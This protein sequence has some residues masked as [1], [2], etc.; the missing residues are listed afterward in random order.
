[1]PFTFL[2]YK[3][4]FKNYDLVP[5]GLEKN[6]DLETAISVFLKLGANFLLESV[7]KENSLGRFTYLSW[8]RKRE[9]RVL[10]QEIIYQDFFDQDKKQVKQ[11]KKIKVD[12]PIQ[13]LKQEIK[14][15]KVL[16]MENLPPFLGGYLG[17]LGFE[18]IH[19]FEEKVPVH[20]RKADDI[21]DAILIQP[22]IIIAYDNVKKKLSFI[23]LANPSE[24]NKKS[25]ALI[26]EK[27]NGLALKLEKPLK[28]KPRPANLQELNEDNFNFFSKED[29]RSMVKKAVSYIKEGEAYQVVLSG[30]FSINTSLEPFEIYRTLKSLNPSPYLFYLDF[31]DFTLLG[32]SPEV[33]VRVDREEM[34][35]RPLAGTRRRGKNLKEDER[36]RKELLNDAKE[37]AEHIMLIDLGRNDLSRIAKTGSVK[38]EDYMQV[39]QYSQVQHIVSTVKADK[40]KSKN[41][42][43]VLE[44]TFPAGTLSGSPKIRAMEII[45]ELEKKRRNFYGGTVFTLGEDGDLNSCITIRSILIKNKKATI[46]A[47]AGIVLNSK[48]DKEYQECFNKSSAL[49]EAIKETYKRLS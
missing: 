26:N 16:K 25:F 43:D 13:F 3:T 34:F 35:L 5:V 23:Y 28:Y 36:L 2:E 22:E 40:L 44:A 41:A 37:R 1:M 30:R 46:Q 6:A 19:F 49:V 9:I 39:D 29:Y 42:W 15:K 24:A 11:L 14:A 33:M 12:N 18:M 31:G 7:E 47:G 45:H 20:A 38:V 4:A 10:G 27:L 17:Y 32:S 21:P 8:G 48:P